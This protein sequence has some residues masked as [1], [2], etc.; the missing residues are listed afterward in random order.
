M[1]REESSLAALEPEDL[2]GHTIDELADYLD[3]GMQPPDPSIDESAACRNALAALVRLRR[4]SH[5]AI[6]AAALEESPADDSWVGE[7][8]A[9]ISLEARSGRDIPLRPTSPTEH[10]VLTEGAV[11]ALVRRAGDSV[12]GV[13][14]GRCAL[15]GDVDVPGEPIRV[16]ISAS[17]VW[18]HPIPEVAEA[19]RTAVAHELLR[20]TELT[21]AGI[22]VEFRDVHLGT[23][24]R[25]EVES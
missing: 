23:P 15:E 17:I 2:D 5:D 25:P 10:G 6:E 7:I 1:T 9:N 24:R 3:R 18:G 16:R 20:H 8:M 14:I 21:V 13:L 19:V 12:D 22:D 4:A 11:R